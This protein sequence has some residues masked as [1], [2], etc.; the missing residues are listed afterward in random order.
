MMPEARQ[1]RKLVLERYVWEQRLEIRNLL[2]LYFGIL[3]ATN[4]YSILLIE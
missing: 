2:E 1:G 3:C 4:N